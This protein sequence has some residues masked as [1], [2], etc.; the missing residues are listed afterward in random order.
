MEAVGHVVAGQLDAREVGHPLVLDIIT[1]LV[2]PSC[3]ELCCPN[4]LRLGILQPGLWESCDSAK[5]WNKERF[6][7]TLGLPA[8]HEYLALR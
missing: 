4:Q 6:A 5:L 2:C 3:T 7:A 1:A 8:S